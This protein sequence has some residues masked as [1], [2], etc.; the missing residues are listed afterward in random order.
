MVN[1]KEDTHECRL[2]APGCSVQNDTDGNKHARCVQVDSCQSIY[3]RSTAQN[4]H[5][6]TANQPN[7]NGADPL[8]MLPH[9]CTL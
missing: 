5:L 7:Y 1:A 8:P 2:E 3:D 9:P 4:Q 6:Q